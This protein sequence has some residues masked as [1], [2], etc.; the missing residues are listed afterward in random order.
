MVP[1]PLDFLE[2]LVPPPMKETPRDQSKPSRFDPKER[3]RRRAA[4][5]RARLA[6]RKNR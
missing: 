2:H 3:A 1:H 6:R 5:K 4:A